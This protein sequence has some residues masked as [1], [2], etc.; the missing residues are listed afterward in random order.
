MVYPLFLS[1]VCL[2]LK[3]KKS[4]LRVN[5][6]HPSDVIWT[7]LKTG[8]IYGILPGDTKLLPEPIITYWQLDAQEYNSVKFKLKY[9][10]FHSRK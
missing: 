2:S 4:K 7:L 10:K 5:S 6:L 1:A 3:L 8:L 9:N